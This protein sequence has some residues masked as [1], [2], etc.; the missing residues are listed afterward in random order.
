MHM[1]DQKEQTRKDL[2]AIQ[3]TIEQ[4]IYEQ[5]TPKGGTP[6]K[7]LAVIRALHYFIG[8]CMRLI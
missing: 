3:D 8:V 1:S 2:A 7:D 6:F 4:I 5:T